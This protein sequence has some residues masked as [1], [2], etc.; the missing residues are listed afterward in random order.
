MRIETLLRRHQA[1]KETTRL[2][3]G[4]RVS[5]AYAGVMASLTGLRIFLNYKLFRPSLPEALPDDGGTVLSMTSFPPRIKHLWMVVDLL[6]RQETKPACINLC[7]YEGDFPDRKLPGSLAPYLERGLRIIWAGE[8]LKPHLKYH[9]TFK[10]EAEGRRRPVI[11]VDDDLFYPT[12]MTTKLM[13][14]HGQ[15]PS[16]V[17]AN[18]AKRIK[19]PMYNGWEI[20]TQAHSPDPELLA[21]GFGAVLYPSSFYCSECIFDLDAIRETCLKADDL[22]LKRCEN[23]TGT[24]VAT[25]GFMAVPPELPS[26][27]KISLSSSNVALGRND[28]A[29][30]ALERYDQTRK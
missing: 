29:W 12:D 18:I 25:G 2:H 9:C 15:Y 16:A 3:K 27:Q 7:L 24:G 8:D 30:A 4:N 28:I 5:R 14:L 22:W 20:E 19:G 23:L 11:T 26:S 13:K 1:F 21:L 6:M 17:C 10:E